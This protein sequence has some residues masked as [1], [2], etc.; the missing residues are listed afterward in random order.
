MPDADSLKPWLRLCD[1]VIMYLFHALLL[2][3]GHHDGFMCTNLLRSTIRSGRTGFESLGHNRM[4]SEQVNQGPYE[5]GWLV[6]IKMSDPS[7]L[8]TLLDS[9]AY[10]AKIA[11]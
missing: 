4:F 6:K 11:E 8:D 2:Q 1:P 10:K 7:E 5:G 9:E 3:V